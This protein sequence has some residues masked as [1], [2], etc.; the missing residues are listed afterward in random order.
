M[1]L[2]VIKQPDDRFAIWSSNVDNFVVMGA[3]REEVIDHFV[4][5]ASKKAR[6]YIVDKLIKIEDD[7][8]AYFQFSRSFKDCLETIEQVHGY[9]ERVKVWNLIGKIKK[10]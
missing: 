4:E 10:E 6:E 9:E 8:K 2:Q 5:V 3:D 7:E 1:G